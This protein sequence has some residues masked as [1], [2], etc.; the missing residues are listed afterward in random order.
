[1]TVR[2]RVLEARLAEKIE[3]NPAL[4]KTMGLEI[5]YFN[6]NDIKAKRKNLELRK[7]GGSI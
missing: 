1:M 5:K 4:A 6:E 2:Q 3:K 7:Q